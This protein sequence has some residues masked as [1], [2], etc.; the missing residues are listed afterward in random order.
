MT[1]GINMHPMQMHQFIAARWQAAIAAPTIPRWRSLAYLCG[2]QSECLCSRTVFMRDGIKML[3]DVAWQRSID[4][5][6]VPD[7]ER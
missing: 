6:P 2:F 3:G 7:Y 5:Q 1:T 4:L